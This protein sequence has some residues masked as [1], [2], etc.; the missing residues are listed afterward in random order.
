M[1]R[2]VLLSMLLVFGVLHG[3]TLK[4]VK[5]AIPAK[6]ISEVAFTEVDGW[7]LFHTPAGTGLWDHYTS[8]IRV[9][10]QPGFNMIFT[11][12]PEVIVIHG[13][14]W[15]GFLIVEDD[16]GYGKGWSIVRG[17]SMVVSPSLTGANHHIALLDGVLR[18]MD[19]RTLI[20][21]TIEQ[22]DTVLLL[23]HNTQYGYRNDAVGRI[24]GLN[25][26]QVLY[27]FNGEVNR[28]FGGY[29]AEGYDVPTFISSDL[30]ATMEGNNWELS[31]GLM[32][33]ICDC[34]SNSVQFLDYGLFAFHSKGSWGLLNNRTGVVTL[35]Q[36]D[37]LQAT[38]T[39][40]VIITDDGMFG[41][42]TVDG[43][44]IAQP[45]YKHIELYEGH[46][47]IP[48]DQY[49]WRLDDK[50]YLLYTDGLERVVFEEELNGIYESIYYR[51][52]SGV[53]HTLEGHRLITA[54]HGRQT[55]FDS[56]DSLMVYSGPGTITMPGQPL[57][58]LEEGDQLICLPNGYYLLKT[59]TSDGVWQ[60]VLPEFMNV[61]DLAVTD[62][63]W[64]GNTL[65]VADTSGTV[66]VWK[67]DMSHRGI[68]GKFE[69]TELWIEHGYL[70]IGRRS[71]AEL[72]VLESQYWGYSNTNWW[73]TE[74][75]LGH[76]GVESGGFVTVLETDRTWSLVDLES[77][78]RIVEGAQSIT[79]NGTIAT[80]VKG[81]QE[82]RL[83]IGRFD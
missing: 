20:V 77:G 3:Q 70:C 38:S 15:I 43:E 2:Y 5:K 28:H 47:I 9:P 39:P 65:V 24:I 66:Y 29:R 31:T 81:G 75:S 7:Y 18:R 76:G 11:P 23:N 46:D 58:F 57:L 26:G 68:L 22:V 25:T 49:L 1:R 40:Y 80:I 55:L 33:F 51:Y 69:Q 14:D 60:V 32:S 63:I 4:E 44:V 61:L 8:E 36:Y 62:F 45:V 74:G 72:M 16:Q 12:D 48:D 21:T 52:A 54:R 37:Q 83:T 35:P 50:E 71:N 82:E 41:L 42:M 6:K 53:A 56:G 59:Y 67:D 17:D 34:E 19:H 78:Q 10:E 79:V 27:E 13:T 30:S 64:Y 73:V